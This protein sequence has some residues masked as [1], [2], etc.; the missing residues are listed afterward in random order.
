MERRVNGER[1][2]KGWS[3]WPF[4]G[5]LHSRLRL[6]WKKPILKIFNL[7]VTQMVSD[8]LWPRDAE[9]FQGVGEGGSSR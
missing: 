8:D 1:P 3:A 2:M 4:P 7:F 9:T 6:K 5:S